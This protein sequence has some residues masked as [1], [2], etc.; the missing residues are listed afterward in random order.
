ME[1][2]RGKLL[3]IGIVDANAH[4]GTH[5]IAIPAGDTFFLPNRF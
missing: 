2:S 3:S 5:L 4:I 1:F